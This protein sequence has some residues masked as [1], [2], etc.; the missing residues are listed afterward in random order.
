MSKR[1][2]MVLEL[3]CVPSFLLSALY[4]L[5]LLLKF[6]KAIICLKRSKCVVGDRIS[7]FII[8]GM[9]SYLYSIAV[10]LYF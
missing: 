4:I 2:I 5:F 3:F 6:P 1:L 8:K 7:S 9:L 10:N